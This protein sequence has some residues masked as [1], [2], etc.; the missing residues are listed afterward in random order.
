MRIR[1]M[2]IP[3]LEAVVRYSSSVTHHRGI[4]GSSKQGAAISELARRTLRSSGIT[5]RTKGVERLRIDSLSVLIS[6][7][8]PSVISGAIAEETDE[9]AI[10]IVLEGEPGGF[11]GGPDPRTLDGVWVPGNPDELWE[12]FGSAVLDLAAAGYPGCIGCAG[13]AAELPWDEE[14]SRSRLR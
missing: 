7:L 10:A 3:L 6:D 9:G 4:M 13:P 5:V 14:A 1:N 11:I 2:A 8:A 12:E